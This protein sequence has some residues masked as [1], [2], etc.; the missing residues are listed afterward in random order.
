MKDNNKILENWLGE[1]TLNMLIYERA[2]CFLITKHILQT[3]EFKPETNDFDNVCN[4]LYNDI[5]DFATED[6][7]EDIK[8]L[9]KTNNIIIKN[10]KKKLKDRFNPFVLDKKIKEKKI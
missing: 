8:A 9:G 7:S 6:L 5:I 10:V 3:T 4:G 2:L 1:N